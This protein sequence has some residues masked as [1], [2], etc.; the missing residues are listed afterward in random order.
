MR[1]LD[2]AAVYAPSGWIQSVG[3]FEAGKQVEHDGSLGCFCE[4][5]DPEPNDRG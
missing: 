3:T 1:E 5:K 2:G 4:P